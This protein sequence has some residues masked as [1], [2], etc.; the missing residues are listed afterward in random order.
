[1]SFSTVTRS[2]S[3]Q[4]PVEQPFQVEFPN[5]R[6]AKAIEICQ[7]S[8][9]ATMLSRLGLVEPRPVLVV[10][11]GASQLSEVDFERVRSLFTEIFAPLAERLGLYVVDGGTDAGVMRM[12]GLARQQVKGTFPLIGVVPQGVAIFPNQAPPQEMAA[13]LEAHHSHFVLTPGFNW[14]DEAGYL[15]KIATRLSDPF[16][17]VSV[18]INGGEITWVDAAESVSEGRSIIV[19]GGSGR[20][21]DTLTAALN[22]H[23]TDPRARSLI[24]SGL[25]Q[26]IDLGDRDQLEAVLQEIL[27][28]L[29]RGH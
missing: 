24:N 27:V 1:M 21:A 28:G 10:V 8:D 6:V 19:I 22:G 17:S 7:S 13:P 5:G 3:V 15:A 4:H 18:L 12:M 11:G 29:N 2:Q 9:L 26:A 20:A 16:P 23:E 14:G 25:L